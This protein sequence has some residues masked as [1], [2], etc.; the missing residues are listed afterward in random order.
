MLYVFGVGEVPMS[1]SGDPIGQSPL[2][3]TTRVV[4]AVTQRDARAE[5]RRTRSASAARS[6]ATGRSKMPRDTTW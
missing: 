6:E 4:G 2:V 3:H 5:A 1:I